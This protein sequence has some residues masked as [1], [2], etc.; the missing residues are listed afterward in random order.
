[1][2]IYVLD[3]FVVK[4]RIREH[5]HY[6]MYYLQINLEIEKNRKNSLNVSIKGI[7]QWSVNI[8]T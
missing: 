8:D 1:M 7:S 6:A 3:L 5:V 2:Y 4:D